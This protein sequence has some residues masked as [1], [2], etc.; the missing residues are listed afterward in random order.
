MQRG[1]LQASLALALFA[2]G[3]CAWVKMEPGAAQVRVLRIGDDVSACKRLGEVATSVRS[4]VGPYQRDRLN[5]RDEL[6]TLARN[7]ALTLHA[8]SVRPE[9]EPAAGRQRW[10]AY[11]C[12][13]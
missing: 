11:R 9:A 3:G 13:A 4:S 10:F 12:K 7:E 8:D 2:V 1:V 5:V 6:E